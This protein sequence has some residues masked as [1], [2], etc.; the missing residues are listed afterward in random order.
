M[1]GDY[2][3]LVLLRTFSKIHSLAGL[4]IGYGVGH[5]DL[6]AE[7]HKTREPFNV[8]MLSQ[9]AAMA[10]IDAWDEVAG[11]ASAI[12]NNCEWME[13]ELAE[14]GFEVVPSQTNFILVRT[15]GNAGN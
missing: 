6:I 4:R 13:T 8:N 11:R 9:A 5:P 12:G 1:R 3:N 15:P 7:L 10:C 14:L 2:P